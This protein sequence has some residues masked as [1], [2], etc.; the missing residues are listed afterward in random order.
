MRQSSGAP[1]AS[2]S[3]RTCFETRSETCDGFAD[4]LIEFADEELSEGEARRVAD[5]LAECPACQQELQLLRRSLDLAQSI[6]E[7]A[8]EDA[9]ARYVCNTES[10]G[11]RVRMAAC[12]AASV[13]VVAA[14]FALW[15]PWRGGPHGVVEQTAQNGHKTTTPPPEAFDEEMDIEAL[16]AREG[17]SARLAASAELL[18]TQPGLERYH[19]QARRYLAE[20]YRGTVAADR[21]APLAVP[22]VKEPEL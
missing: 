1:T 15:H 8:A 14:A 10:P 7:Q 16:I 12:V 20:T 2:E 3:R 22:P 13:A 19:R 5:H 6:W 4:L 11:R 17:R 9:P 18:A 21:I